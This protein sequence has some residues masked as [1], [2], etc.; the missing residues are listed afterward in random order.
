MDDNWQLYVDGSSTNTRCGAGLIL[1]SPNGFQ[2]KQAIQ[3]NFKAMNNQAEYEAFLAGLT[4]AKNLQ[5]GKITI[6]SD[7]QLV[8]RQTTGDYST[9]DTS[10]SKY[11]EMVQAILSQFEKYILE[12]ID[13]TD[14]T[15]A[16]MLSKLTQGEKMDFETVYFE[17]LQAPSIYDLPIMEISPPI[18]NWM[19]PY[20]RYLE[21][22]TLPDDSVKAKVLK[23]QATKY[24]IQEGTLYKRS[25]D[26]P[27]LKCVDEEEALYC[28]WEVHEGICGDHMAGKALA[29]KILR[30]GYYWPKMHKECKT[31]TKR[32]HQC[33]LF[34]NMSRKA[35]VLPAAILSPIPFAVWGIDIMGPFPKAKDDLQYVMVAIDY[36]TKW[37]EA[38][39]L[40]NITQ[41]DAIR[42]VTEVNN[43]WHGDKLRKY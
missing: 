32:C 4:L 21:S 2:V 1:T 26:S 41:D 36:M 20:V 30:Q 25:F 40:K 14:N 38:K 9:K 5:V 10:L 15:M 29:H 7:S 31:F 24:F 39:A 8:V 43:T 13:R 34:S 33:Q 27:I 35:Q 16:N 3:L 12:Q 42:F 37:A 28:M 23:S 22:G 18:D 6:Y 17:E 11:Q 19:T